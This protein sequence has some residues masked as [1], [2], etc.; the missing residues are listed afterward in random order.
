MSYLGPISTNAYP[1]INYI[2]NGR[3]VDSLNGWT[4]YDETDSVTFQDVGDTVTLNNHGLQNGQIVMFRSESGGTNI[5]TIFRY[6]VI[7]ATTNTFQVSS[8]LNGGAVSITANGTG[9][10]TRDRPKLGTGGSPVFRFQRNTTTPLRE[11]ADFKLL[12]YP[13]IGSALGGLGQGISYDFEINSADQ[14]KVLTVSFDYSWLL[15]G[16]TLGTDLTNTTFAVYLIQDPTGTPVVIQPAG[17]GIQVASV[18]TKMRHIATFQTASNVTRYR[19]CIHAANVNNFQN[20]LAFDNFQVGPQVVQYGAPV[21]DWQSYTPTITGTANFTSTARYRRVGDSME[22]EG[23]VEMTGAATG[24]IYVS[25]P[26]GFSIDTSKMQKGL[27]NTDAYQY[28]GECLAVDSGA[29]QWNGKVTRDNLSTTRFYFR[30]AGDTGVNSGWDNAVPFTWG[31]GDALIFKV[32]APILGW[33]ST[34]QMSNDTDTRVVAAIITG[35]PASASSGNPI[36][37]PTVSSDTHNAYNATTGRYTVPVPGF[38]KMFGALQSASSA[39]TL[40][41][42]KNAVSTQLAGSLDSNGEATFSGMVSCVA[43]DIIDI[44][45]GGT[46]DATSMSLNI[47]RVSGPSAIAA[48]ETIAC[49]YI[50]TAGN[51]INNTT[52][53]FIDFATRQGDTHGAVVG[54]GSGNNTTATSTWRFVAPISGRYLVTAAVGFNVPVSIGFDTYIRICVDGSDYHFGSRNNGTMTSATPLGLTASGEIQL[55]AGQYISIKAYQNTGAARTMT[56]ASGSNRISII[57]VGN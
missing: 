38:Y 54:A 49:E 26:S 45:P 12:N 19:L 20:E 47:E 2:S 34:V 15:Q 57:R 7:N 18:G 10:M 55:N 35:D 22:V 3:A 33:S 14:A 25:F 53:T 52:D 48:N 6:Y 40:T 30:T 43:G 39:T 17:F 32:K 16:G 46:V 50:S 11:V 41:I 4:V 37:V 23:S 1:V 44:R 9:V 36:I 13:I 56:T 21:T 8:I 27:L 51:T 29:N 28:L 42:F 31:N 5:S 24:T